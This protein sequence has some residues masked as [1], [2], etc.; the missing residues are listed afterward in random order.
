MVTYSIVGRDAGTG[1]FG[2]AVQSQAFN[3]GA[4][5][6]WA[7]AGVG[8]IATQAFTDRRY[9]WRGLELI[10]SGQAPEDVLADLRAEDA[11]ASFRQVGILSADGRTAQW[12]GGDCV[13]EAGCASGDGW[14]AQ[15]NTVASQQVW[16]V[17]GEVFA[18]S[19]GSLA[20]RL[21]SALEAAESEG[22]DWR[23]RAAAA[24]V[25]VPAQGERWERIIDL[26]VE[27]SPEPL[28]ELRRLLDRALAYRETNRA[29]ADRA[30]IGATRGLPDSHVR[31]L[32]LE[33]AV[34][35]G[36]FEDAAAIL[37]DLE[38]EDPRWLDYVHTLSGHPEM[39]GLARL[40][41]R[42]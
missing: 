32:S 22:G 21:L 42:R 18:S 13:P 10:A 40:L 4:G 27:E 7:W 33:D 17:M 34:E 8:A 31:L 36:R 6:P 29:T 28:A 3:C 24:I 19:D 20:E 35:E 15:A 23:G 39:E 1:E 5:V 12:T 37:D 16:K 38:R 9:G 2:V 26:R 41:A 25:V 14:I 11:L 30:A